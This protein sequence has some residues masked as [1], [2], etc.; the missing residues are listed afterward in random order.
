MSN[1][2]D[3]L[4]PRAAISRFFKYG[5]LLIALAITLKIVFDGFSYYLARRSLDAELEAKKVSSLEYLVNLSKRER[6]L[7]IDTI[8][9]RCR[10]RNELAL[11]RIGDAQDVGWAGEL[12]AGYVKSREMRNRLVDVVLGFERDRSDL[13]ASVNLVDLRTTINGLTFSL[14]RAIADWRTVIKPTMSVKRD[15]PKYQSAV[16]EIAA[17]LVAA[18]TPY[19]AELKSYGEIAAK[20][21]AKYG[22][23]STGVK[24]I[25][26][27][28]QRLARLK[29]ARDQNR[30]KMKDLDDV[31]YRYAVWTSALS[32]GAGES[33]VLD[34][35]AFRIDDDSARAIAQVDCDNL[36]KYYSK[37][38]GTP[39]SAA[40][41]LEKGDHDVGWLR[42]LIS[43]PARLADFYN[44]A[45]SNYF[46]SPPVAQTLFVTLFLGALGALTINVLRLSKIGWW[47]G[48]PDP[49]WG[50]VVL[51][52]LLGALAAFGIFLLGSSGLLLTSDAKA[53]GATSLSAFFIGLLGFIS[54][55]LY[56]DAFGRVRRFGAQ[57]FAGED[58]VI[59][60]S[61]EDR[62]LAEALRV[63]KA[64]FAADLVLKFGVG[65][66]LSAEPE[67][68]LLVP[69]DEAMSRLTLQA[70]KDISEPTTRTRF[71]TWLRRHHALKRVT[72]ADV[73]ARTATEIQ[74]EEGKYPLT[75]DGDVLKVGAVKVVSADISWGNGVIHVV[76][77]DL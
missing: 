36:N 48:Q 11:F 67:F 19:L 6:A 7:V 53:S 12:Q 59:P 45:V 20:I 23:D 28:E 29:K 14:A 13:T 51:C 43:S 49:Q 24:A 17:A 70:W 74:T 55:L 62:S 72:K 68:T 5:F 41:Q 64:S 66:R 31:L 77:E 16:D 47:G 3:Y 75:V 8:Q 2:H 38:N 46:S 69:S 54:G 34:E 73:A 21:R 33:P 60:I 39:F 52:P 44:D 22:E 57:L 71:E 1:W 27:L 61:A 30:E 42:R 9:T 58:A 50:E 10:E 18:A 65:K 4:P 40:D 76:A 63:A 56:E 32:A 15:D 25:E 35:M 26:L 37:I